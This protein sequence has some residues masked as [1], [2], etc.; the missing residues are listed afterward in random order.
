[1]NK[2]WK[3]AG[4][5]ALSILGILYF[6]FLFILPNVI[7]INQYVPVL[8]EIAKEQLNLN[9][10]I[11][12]PKIIT[13]PILEAG[14][15]TDDIKITLS[16]GSPVLESDG[17]KAKVFLP[18]AL[19][20]SVKVSC[21]ELHNPKITLDTNPQA[22]QYKLVQEIETMLDRLNTQKNEQ[23]EEEENGWFNPEWIR[24]KVPNA[25][26]SNYKITVNDLKSKHNLTLKG[27][28][29][30]LGYINGKRAKLKTY[31][32]L[33]SDNKEN[34][35][36]NLN[37][38][39]FWQKHE[40]EQLDPDDDKAQKI[41]LPFVNIVKI[42][43]H[44]D[45]QAHINSKIKIRQNKHGKIKANGSFDIDNFT[46]K[47][48]NYQLP[49]CYFHSKMRGT[50]AD[51]DTNFYVTPDEKASI[52]GKIDYNKPSI[53]LAIN[54]DKIHFNNLILF[55]KAIL[56]SFGI[57]NDFNNLRGQGFIEA[58]TNIK[59]NFKK[60]KS[61]GK[62]I[63]RDGALIN[64]KI[65]LLITNTNAD[66]NFDN[67]IFQIKNT[68][69]LIGGKE[70]KVNGTIDN[71][72]DTNITA[73]TQNMPIVGLYNAFAPSDLKKN[74]KMNSGNI[75]LN[76]KINGKLRTSLSSLKFDL[77]N[78]GIAT[79]DNSVNINNG[80]L[81]ITAEYD[82]SK[83]TFDG[84]LKNKNFI[85]LLPQTK[86]VI[87]DNDTE[88]TIN[89]S[90][91][92]KYNNLVLPTTKL[93]INNNSYIDIWGNVGGDKH[94]KTPVIDFNGNGKLSAS[95]LRKFGGDAALPYI[96][97][98]GNLPVKFCLKGGGKRHD[99]VG[100]ILS[101]SGNYITPVHFRNLLGKQ[102]LAQAKI[103]YK[104][105]R[106]NIKD[107]GL[108]ITHAPFTSDLNANMSG[109][110]PVIK[111]HGTLAKLDTIEPRINMLKLEIP[112]PL[113]GTIYA[114]KRSRFT[115][116]GD[117]LTIGKLEKPFIHGGVNVENLN[118]PSLLTKIGNTGIQFNG[119]SMKLF[120]DNIDLNGSDMKIE[121]HSNFEFSPVT[122]LFKLDINSNNFDL[123]KVMKVSEAA[124]KNL[125]QVP[126]SASK[127]SAKE[128]IIPLDVSGRFLFRHI[129]T[130]N[131]NLTNTRGRLALN[132]NIL[133]LRPMMTNCFK[134][135]VRGKIDTNIVTGA[136]S[137]DLKG[138]NIDVE[139]ALA[140]AANT[141]DA[142][143]GTASFDMK[144]EMKGSSYEEQMKSLKGGVNFRINN[145]GYGPIGKIENLILAEN[146]RNSQFFQTAL[147]GII[148]NIATIDTAHFTELK[149]C[150]KF[151]DGKAIIT[152]ITSQGNVMCLHIAGEYDLLKNEADMKVRGR[153]GS[154]LSNMLGPIA[155]LN[156]VNLVKATPGINVVMAKAFSLFTV[157]VTPEE[158]KAIPD[159]A[160]GQPDLTATK[161]QIV[162][163]GDASKPLSMIKSFKWLATQADINNA[164]NFTENLPEEYLLADPTTP[165]AQAAA[166]AKA[167]E[168]AKII[169]R[170][171]RKF[172][173][174]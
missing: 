141:K 98:K 70:V 137:M 154:F 140:D 37:I 11:K 80:N 164:Q 33:M 139:Q 147:G 27:D 158:M 100:Q 166:A 61:D 161:F 45:L 83:G 20:L 15:K 131:I 101:N 168:D 34:I 29:L 113:N 96:D 78:L 40:K 69:S 143:S 68:R 102:C 104:G 22:T 57:R 46:L 133:S 150:I 125:P 7:D 32:Y 118:I 107:T 1:M 74:I 115:L 117:I 51:I 60:L 127:P 162:L 36:A 39:T 173:K 174:G 97:A 138:H 38:N 52:L 17:L 16:D 35:T 157:A 62:I 59:T 75:S 146:I 148:N 49:K 19:V 94:K 72:S 13:T 6:A 153:L 64:N 123:D 130:G 26:A 91:N 171:K 31:A 82:S 4:I 71:D 79:R 116:N 132:R 103:T 2:G 23:I 67:N 92:F 167:K 159:F 172:K 163:R 50:T 42:Y 85:L 86:S 170:V 106:L 142:I 81:N 84:K 155:A 121:A 53:D 145:G 87:K 99:F 41:E 90:S 124:A 3:I 25:V 73:N 76:A 88:I 44:Y 43:Q 10:E 128:E 151:K 30:R 9:V 47:L 65:S 119:Y 55:S 134:G 110:E 169:N 48:A 126:A 24:V 54:S 160:K 120:A 165:E 5:T 149:G 135:V 14:I 112:N 144:S 66:L 12:N 21:L 89:S 109:A 93:T 8:Q 114:L 108:F 77:N 111:T 129:K 28:E 63:I 156:P 136:I 152:P 58:N 105:D 56:D 18:S 122:K 95:D